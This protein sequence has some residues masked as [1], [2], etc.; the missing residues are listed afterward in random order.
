MRGGLFPDHWPRCCAA[1]AIGMRARPRIFILQLSAL[2][3]VC[4]SG[5]GQG[6]RPRQTRFPREHIA[7]FG[8]YD[9]DGITATCLLTEYLR[10]KGGHVTSYIPAALKR[11]TG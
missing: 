2:V 7:V 3:A 9:V 1:A 11:A 5:H 8:D 6:C 10:S 4:P